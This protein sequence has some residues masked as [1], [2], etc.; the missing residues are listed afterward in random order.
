M[1]LK[2]S[3]MRLL[4]WL[5]NEND[6]ERRECSARESQRNFNE[7]RLLIVSKLVLRP[8]REWNTTAGF[9]RGPG[10]RHGS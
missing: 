8:S 6:D 7:I 5:S 1:D 10:I 4:L 9:C 3:A 2:S